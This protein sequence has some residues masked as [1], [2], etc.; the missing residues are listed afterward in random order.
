MRMMPFATRCMQN[1]FHFGGS[2]SEP[3]LFKRRYAPSAVALAIAK[4]NINSIMRSVPSMRPLMRPSRAELCAE[5]RARPGAAARDADTTAALRLEIE[6]LLLT[7]PPPERYFGAIRDRCEGRA[8]AR[9]EDDC[10]REER[11][12]RADEI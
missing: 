6:L 1:A 7:L 4:P 3:K 5:T 12:T 9:R 11:S 2:S 8:R 10:A